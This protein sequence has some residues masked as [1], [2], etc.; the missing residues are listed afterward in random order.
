MRQRQLLIAFGILLLAAVTAMVWT[1]EWFAPN[2]LHREQTSSAGKIVDQSPLQTAQMLAPQAATPE[3]QALAQEA[4]HTADQEVDLAFESALRNA[5][6]HPPALTAEARKIGVQIADL[7]ARVKVGQSRVAQLDKQVEAA[8]DSSKEDDLRQEL[9]LTQAQLD[10]DEDDLTEAKEDLIRAGG[11]KRSLIQRMM[12][13]RHAGQPPETAASKTTV[14]SASRAAAPAPKPVETPRSLVGQI[15]AWSDLR[16]KQKLLAQ[17]QKEASLKAS[18]LAETYKNLQSQVSVAK[19]QKSGAV[20][21]RSISKESAAAALAALQELSSRQ[22]NLVKFD[23]RVQAEKELGDIYGRWSALVKTPQRSISHAIAQSL[24][25]ILFLVVLLLST[26]LLIERYFADLTPERKRLRTLRNVV[27]FAVQALGAVLILLIIFGP[28]NQLATVLALAGAGLTV[29]L[30]DFIV[31]FFG[32]FVL[33][34]RNG[35][36]IGDWVEINGVGGEVV[37]IDLL[38][39]VLLETGNWNDAGHPTG[40]RVSFVN[41]YAI[42]GHYFNFSTSGQWLWDEL[43]VLVPAG[44]DPTAMALAFQKVVAADTEANARLAEQEWQHV[45]SA[46]KI[47]SFTAAPG[48]SVRPTGAGIEI[49]VRYITR[50]SERQEVRSRLYQAVVDILQ[51]KKLSRNTSPLPIVAPEQHP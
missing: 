15:S 4:L 45:A 35:I 20:A 47:S 48:V 34:G 41:S 16:S 50:A 29:A 22:Q 46:R 36:R 51:H 13:E 12:E 31:G 9:D 37:E 21:Q 44:E 11:D 25:L 26:D 5:I 18:E 32:W 1:G 10:L 8:T 27:R 30:K 14:S 28:P 17:A 40:R 19:K 49:T 33:M 24:V 43:R 42:E 39:T 2:A 3:E 6:E 7:E 38:H 23:K